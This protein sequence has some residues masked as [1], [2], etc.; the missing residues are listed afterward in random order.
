MVPYAGGT[1]NGG[2]PFP[3]Q[4]AT[5]ANYVAHNGCSSTPGSTGDFQIGTGSSAFT[6]QTTQYDSGCTAGASVWQWDV[7]GSNHFAGSTNA[8]FGLFQRGLT[9]FLLP[10]TRAR[11]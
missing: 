9:T 1:G 5:V 4:L 10:R 11:S 2:L 7:E 3:G 6:V 8:S